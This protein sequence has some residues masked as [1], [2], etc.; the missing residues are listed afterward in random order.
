MRGSRISGMGHYVPE[1]VVT[2]HDL[3]KFIDTSDEWIVQRTGIEER[4]WVE[5]NV[6]SSDLAFE[7]A[8]DALEDAGMAAT[9]LDMI[10]F[11]TLS[12]DE[13]SGLQLHPSEKTEHSGVAT[14]DI[15]NQCTGFVWIVHRRSIHQNRHDGQHFG[16]GCGGAFFGSGHDHKRS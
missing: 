9:D 6:G 8:K 16:C 4:R 5:G 2:N 12:P 13:L 10:A 3:A 11:A 1:R 15:R 14:L 7:A